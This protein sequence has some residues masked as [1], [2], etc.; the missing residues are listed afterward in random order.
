[1]GP[2][3]SEA[4]THVLAEQL[5]RNSEDSACMHIYAGICMWHAHF[6]SLLLSILLSIIHLKADVRVDMVPFDQARSLTA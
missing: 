6:K 2:L 5:T 3:A 4:V 1:M